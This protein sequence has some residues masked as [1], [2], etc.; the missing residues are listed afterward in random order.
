VAAI[1]CVA[2]S[3]GGTTSQDL[4]TGYL[5]GATPYAQQIGLLVGAVTSALVIGYTLNLLNNAS[6]IY[7]QK[8][9]PTAI[10]ANVGE[11]TTLEHAD[12]AAHDPTMY[13][14]LHLAETPAEGP[15]ARVA[16]GRYLIDEQGHFKYLVDPGING[17]LK[18]RD[19]GTPVTKYEAPKARLMSLIIDGILTQKLPWGLVLLGVAMAVMME[20]CG[21]PSLPFAVGVYLPLSSSTP[22]FLGGLIRWFVDRRA[23]AQAAGQSATE[24]ETSPG[25]LASSGLI[26]GGAIAG[27]VLALFSIRE[28]WAAKLDFSALWPAF[29]G[30]EGVALAFFLALA[31]FLYWI[32]TR[33]PAAD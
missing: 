23:R 14:V 33:A 11:L 20:L 2:A 30:S 10:V 25:V 22:I 32:G 28:D 19:D 18:T 17:A 3:N 4:K 7:S 21:V 1:V 27:I 31:G 26:A 29:T 15:L 12:G 6:T 5:V 16:P 8:D 24:S 13:H 9:L